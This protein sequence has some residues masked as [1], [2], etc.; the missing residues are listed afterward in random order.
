M[1]DVN[2]FSSSSLNVPLA[3]AA[4]PAWM[5]F[6][7]PSRPTNTVAGQVRSAVADASAIL[8]NLCHVRSPLMNGVEPIRRRVEPVPVAGGYLVTEPSA[9][10]YFTDSRSVTPTVRGSPGCATSNPVL[11]ATA[12]MRSR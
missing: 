1:V 12:D 7:R 2:S 8:Q 4:K 6:T 9:E 11:P 3:G 10:N 5:P